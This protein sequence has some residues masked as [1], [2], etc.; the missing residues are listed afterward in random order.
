MTCVVKAV[1]GWL[2]LMLIGTNLV[3]IVARGLFPI[4]DMQEL[5]KTAHPI[6]QTEVAR[7][8][9]TNLG[10]TLFFALLGILY[11]YLLLRFWNLGVLIAAVML[12]LARLPDLLWEIRTGRKITRRNAPMGIGGVFSVFMSWAALPVLWLALC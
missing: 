12:M 5:E 10:F 11:F 9:R 2:V 3:G 8:K 1:V 4:P 7:Y 6:I